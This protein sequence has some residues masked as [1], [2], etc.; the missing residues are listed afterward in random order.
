MAELLSRVA[1]R[2]PTRV[3]IRIINA[4]SNK[5]YTYADLLSS[6]SSVSS[7][8]KANLSLRSSHLNLGNNDSQNGAH[9]YDSEPM[10]KRTKK[11]ASCDSKEPSLSPPKETT[12][13]L[14][15]PSGVRLRRVDCG[16]PR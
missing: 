12:V 15:A 5:K 4:N 11:I 13:A 2:Y 10:K 16:A 14:M 9:D 8:L 6:S 1:S 7:L 3:A